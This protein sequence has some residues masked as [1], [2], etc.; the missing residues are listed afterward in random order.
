MLYVAVWLL[1]RADIEER[2]QAKNVPKDVL[3]LLEVIRTD[4]KRLSELSREHGDFFADPSW[5]DP[6]QGLHE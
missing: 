5:R 3:E 4:V 1:R 2:I 6:I